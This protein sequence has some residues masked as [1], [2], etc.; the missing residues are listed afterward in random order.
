MCALKGKKRKGVTIDSIP[1][2]TSP[3][4]SPDWRDATQYPR[5]G[6]VSLVQFAWEFLRRNSA[7][8]DAWCQYLETFRRLSHAAGDDIELSGAIRARAGTQ[9]AWQEWCKWRS[10]EAVNATLIKVFDV[11]GYLVSVGNGRRV[12]LPAHF[13]APWGLR[14]IQDP[15]IDEPGLLRFTRVAAAGC[16]EINP[17]GGGLYN[18]AAG[19]QEQFERGR[20][21]FLQIDLSLPLKSIDDI[22]S[23]TIR[24]TRAYRA[25]RGDFDTVEQR[26]RPDK[27]VEYLRILDAVSSG[28]SPDD[29]GAC[30]WPK[31]ANSY[32]HFSRDRRLEAAAR[33]AERLRDGGYGVLPTLRDKVVGGWLKSRKSKKPAG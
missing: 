26:P 1:T 11:P 17:R 23:R 21:L 8:G 6:A 3:F 7:Y 2:S 10:S 4:V 22:V 5:P 28:V 33:E 32:P 24:L 19:E 16:A 30:L 29:I 14:E 15:S 27:Y 31:A 25:R 12:P 18:A 9:A 13:G 20:Y